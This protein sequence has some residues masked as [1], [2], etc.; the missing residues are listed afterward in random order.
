MERHCQFRLVPFRSNLQ[1]LQHKEIERVEVPDPIISL[2]VE[3]FIDREY[4]SNAT[5]KIEIYRR[6]VVVREDKE[7][8]DL[9]EELE[10]RFG[11]ITEPVENLLLVARI[12]V[13]AKNLGVRSITEKDLRVEFV[14]SDLKRIAAQGLIDLSKIF[15]R[16]LKFIE[17]SQR[18]FITFKS[19]TNLLPRVLNV[20]K[21][22]KPN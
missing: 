8:D 15:R 22:L 4:I 17:S 5:D 20:L 13:A 21:S 3:A 10:D 12:R 1:K 9:R 18:L 7:I 16:D 19:E 11:K 14:F 6:L 2:P